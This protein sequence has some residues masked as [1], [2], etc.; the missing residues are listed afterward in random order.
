[1]KGI[2]RVPVAD[3]RCEPAFRSE[4]TTQ[5]LFNTPVELGEEKDNYIGAALP[6]GYTG[7]MHKN[8]L[9]YP[10]LKATSG[11]TLKVGTPFLPVF[12]FGRKKKISVLTFNSTVQVFHQSGSW[13]AIGS[14]EKTLGWVKKEGLIDP[15][16]IRFSTSALIKK[17]M[18]FFGT[19]YLWGGISPFGFDCSGFL[20]SLFGFFGKPIPRDTV[21]Q[22]KVGNDISP[23]EAKPADLF[24]FPG[25]VALY[26]GQK[27]I[28]H[29]N[30]RGG[31]VTLDSTR[32][33]DKNYNPVIETLVTIKR[34]V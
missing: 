28:L 5:T 19:P 26:C 21:E 9:F 14:S 6:D 18:E 12:D 23:G 27:K 22:I 8:H 13:L 31:G 33:S 32:P 1:M 34:V 15:S 30:L 16:K 10:A 29:S 20:F 11:K 24:F 25:H 2:V 7:W 17:G 3:V 4:R